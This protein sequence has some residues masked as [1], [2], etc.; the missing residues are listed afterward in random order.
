MSL[1]MS[2][3]LGRT[4]NLSLSVLHRNRADG[5]YVARTAHLPLLIC[6]LKRRPALALQC[7]VG[8]PCTLL[9]PARC[10]ARPVLHPMHA[11]LG[12]QSEWTTTPV[13]MQTRGSAA[14]AA[15]ALPSVIQTMP[16][17]EYQWCGARCVFRATSMRANSKREKEKKK[18]DKN[19]LNGM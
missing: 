2:H 12:H 17:V 5:I 13:Q 6:A 19:K 15:L 8:S 4:H 11:V 3:M 9:N 14:V 16:G 18:R 10:R 7:H 1:V